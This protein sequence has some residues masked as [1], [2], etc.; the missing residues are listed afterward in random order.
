MRVVSVSAG[1]VT[2]DM[3]GVAVML[4]EVE[5]VPEGLVFESE[6]EFVVVVLMV[7]VRGGKV[8]KPSGFQE[9]KNQAKHN[10]TVLMKVPQVDDGDNHTI[11]YFL[12]LK[13]GIAPCQSLLSFMSMTYL[14]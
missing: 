2:E 13:T 3:T 7:V 14:L 1:V 6:G 9:D 5:N 8:D 4:R 10:F 11:F 12:L